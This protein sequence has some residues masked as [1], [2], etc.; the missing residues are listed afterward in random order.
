MYLLN[1]EN[2]LVIQGEGFFDASDSYPIGIKT[3]V[4]GNISFAI[5][6]LENFDPEQAIYI[7]DNDTESYHNIRNEKFEVMMP[8][9]VND[10][11]FSLRFI[12]KNNNSKN[13][14]LGTTENTIGDIKISH[15]QNGNI[16]LINNKLMDTVVEKVTLFNILGQSITTWK[17]ENQEQ[18]NIKIPIKNLSSGI[19]VAKVKTS[20]GD[21]SKKIIIP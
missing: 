7:Y 4:E 19:Y 12:N 13:V 20:N 16:L 11:R 8:A 1:G 15:I 14:S 17:I 6:A 3:D 5:D 21:I 2:Q 10:T 18:Q 9:G